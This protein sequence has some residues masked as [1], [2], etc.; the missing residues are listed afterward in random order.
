M[1]E[2]LVG[3]GIILL[4]AEHSGMRPS[5]QQQGELA[6]TSLKRVFGLGETSSATLT[7]S[8]TQIAAKIAAYTHAFLVNRLLVWP[9]G[10]IK[11]RSVKTSQ[12]TSRK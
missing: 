5:V 3:C 10:R 2:A 8:T 11:E 4:M 7:G 12:Q 9:Q 6:L 1:E